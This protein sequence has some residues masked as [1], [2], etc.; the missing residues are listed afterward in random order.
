MSIDGVFIHYLIS[1]LQVIK[2]SKIN[3]VVRI[4]KAKKVKPNHKKKVQQ[5][6]EK[7]KR[8]HR[9]EVIQNDIK[10]RIKQRAIMKN[11]GE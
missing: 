9:R 1:E 4:N 2:G 6:I 7:V 5:A 10:K 8:R 11:K 3:K